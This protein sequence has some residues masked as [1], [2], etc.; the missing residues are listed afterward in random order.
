[1]SQAD[2]TTVVY[3]RSI[4]RLLTSEQREEWMLQVSSTL[5]TLG[6]SIPDP[7]A[8]VGKEKWIRTEFRTKLLGGSDFHIKDQ[9]STV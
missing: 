7:N 4:E 9:V 6:G 1:M 3:E 2:S 5:E 8:F